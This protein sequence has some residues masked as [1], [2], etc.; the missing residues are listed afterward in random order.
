MLCKACNLKKKKKKFG[1]VV[2]AWLC[3]SYKFQ[4]T[5]DIHR[6]NEKQVAFVLG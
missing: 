4:F 2:T 6:L 5:A 3:Y 1:I